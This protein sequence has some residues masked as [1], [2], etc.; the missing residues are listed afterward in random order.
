M[1]SRKKVHFYEM[2]RVGTRIRV[3]MV[4]CLKNIANRNFEKALEKAFFLISLVDYFVSL[5]YP[6]TKQLI[7]TRFFLS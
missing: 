2:F 3:T 5:D 1:H 6:M 4:I 7:S